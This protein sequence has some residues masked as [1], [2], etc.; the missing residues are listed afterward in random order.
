MDNTERHAAG[1]PAKR[2]VDYRLSKWILKNVEQLLLSN[3]IEKI[4]AELLSFY[5]PPSASL[6]NVCGTL[7]GN[8]LGK[9]AVPNSGAIKGGE[10]DG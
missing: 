10:Q 8:G 2:E 6:E 4:W 7:N 9:Y 5:A 3:E 1:A